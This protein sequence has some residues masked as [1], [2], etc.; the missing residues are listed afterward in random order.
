MERHDGRYRR[1]DD[2]AAACADSLLEM[3]G[4]LALEEVDRLDTLVRSQCRFDPM[5]ASACAGAGF[6][7][8][9]AHVAFTLATTQRDTQLELQFLEGLDAFANG[10]SNMAVRYGLAYTDDHAIGTQRR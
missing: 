8:H 6:L 10:A 9:G 4:G 7:E 2:E 1:G 5:E 3:S